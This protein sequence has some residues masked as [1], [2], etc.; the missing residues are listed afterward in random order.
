MKRTNENRRSHVFGKTKS[1]KRTKRHITYDVKDIK[2]KI[3][4]VKLINAYVDLQQ[5]GS[6]YQ[7][8]CPFHRENHPSFTVYPETRSWYCFG[9]GEGGDVIDFIR[10]IEDL[11]FNQA[12]RKLGKYTSI[13][14]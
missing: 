8:V 12:L 14:L 5:S 4:I 2:D 10:L 6:C 1:W 11:D 3:D 9:C 13:N 7:G